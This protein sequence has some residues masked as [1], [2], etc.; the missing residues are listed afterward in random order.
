[1]DGK[2]KNSEI[3]KPENIS[4][5]KAVKTLVGGLT[6]VAAYNVLP[7]KWGTP[8]I[9]SVF[10]PAHAATSGSTITNLQLQI[11]NGDTTT[12]SVDVRITGSVAPATSGT[13][14]NLTLTP[15]T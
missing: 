1:M 10:L 2:I 11:V 3:T 8:I 13:T 14:V 5:R 6:A 9:D 12:D 7:A 15:S 4:R